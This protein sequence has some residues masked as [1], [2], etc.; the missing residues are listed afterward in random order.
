MRFL[1]YI[2]ESVNQAPV[3]EEDKE[4]FEAFERTTLENKD[5]CMSDHIS[6]ICFD[7]ILGKSKFAESEI[8]HFAS[9]LREAYGG[10]DMHLFNNEYFLKNVPL[11]SLGSS[12]NLQLVMSFLCK[13]LHQPLDTLMIRWMMRYDKKEVCELTCRSID[14]SFRV[15]FCRQCFIFDCSNHSSILLIL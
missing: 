11:K 1:P 15:L 8:A 12:A 5:Y 13:T 3:V 2:D 4:F 10:M 9:H 14:E 7:R 6:H